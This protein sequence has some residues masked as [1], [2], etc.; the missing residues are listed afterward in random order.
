MAESK[1][2]QSHHIDLFTPRL[3][4]LLL[5]CFKGGYDKH[6]VDELHEP[7]GV[8]VDG[9]SRKILA[10]MRGTLYLCT[11]K[12]ATLQIILMLVPLSPLR[13]SASPLRFLQ[14]I[15]S[16]SCPTNPYAPNSAEASKCPCTKWRRCS[17]SRCG[18]QR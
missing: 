8:G 10:G 13:C 5:R 17:A 11:L 3:V 2:S 15:K 12:S 7:V 18:V 14:A 9:Y 6:S 16:Q 4:W 1:Q